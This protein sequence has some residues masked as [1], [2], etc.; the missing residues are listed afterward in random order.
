MIGKMIMVGTA[1]LGGGT[2]AMQN[3]EVQEFV[4]NTI[5]HVQGMF[6]GQV[7]DV[8]SVVEVGYQL[9]PEALLETLTDEQVAALTAFV[10]DVNATYDFASMTEEEVLAALADIKVLQDALFDELG[11]EAPQG[12]FATKLRK[13]K[14]FNPDWIPSGD[15]LGDGDCDVEPDAPVD[16]TILDGTTAY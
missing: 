5:E 14:K 9:P 6:R 8:A 1:F 2:A 3:E 16:D 13:G 7:N 15:A 11:I 10:D 12:A 4:G